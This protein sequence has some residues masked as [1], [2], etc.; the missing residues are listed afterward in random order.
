M[1]FSSLGDQRTRSIGTCNRS[2][3]C[4]APEIGIIHQSRWYL[5]SHLCYANRVNTRFLIPKQILLVLPSAC[6]WPRLRVS[7]FVFVVDEPKQEWKC[8]YTSPSCILVCFQI[9]GLGGTTAV[10]C[11]LSDLQTCATQYIW[12]QFCGS[13]RKFKYYDNSKIITMKLFVILD[14]SVKRRLGTH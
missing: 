11:Y 10:C 2:Y 5:C 8:K 13:W 9:T 3:C 7:L 1:V 4:A 12:K 6:C 14:F